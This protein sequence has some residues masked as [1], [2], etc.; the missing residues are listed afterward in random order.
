MKIYLPFPFPINLDGVQLKLTSTPAPIGL[1]QTPF[2]LAA[3]KMP[4]NQVEQCHRAVT[5]FVVKGLHPFATVESPW[6][7]EMTKALNPRYTPPSRTVLS[8]TLIPAWYEVEKQNV[9]TELANVS[10]VAIT[11]DGWTSLAQDHYI[12]VT[13]HY[14]SQ[15]KL[16]QK[17]LQTKAVYRAQTGETVAV[18]IGEVLEEFGITQKVVVMTVDNASNMDVAAKKLDILKLG[19]FAHT[20][21]LAAQKVYSIA[22]MTRWAAKLRAVIVWMKRSSMAKV[23]LKEKQLLLKLPQHTMI[24]DVKT[25]WNSLFLMV[26]RFLEQYPALQAAVLDPRIRKPMERDRLDRITDEDF[27]KA[28]EFIKVMKVLYTS[29]LCVSSEKT[30]TCGQILPILM[31]LKT[32]FTVQEGDSSFVSDIKRKVLTDLSGR[33]QEEKI[34]QFLEEA[35]AM[36][37]S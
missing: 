23:V 33:Y 11:S 29:T 35:T 12:T 19:C 26:E 3:R 21:N 16:Q 27:T 24:L 28:E 1:L 32:H 13:A 36:D 15:G 5:K 34:Q 25:R 8:N 14:S 7:R 9:I 37:P 30:P 22:T 17:V 10:K 6:F 31:K 2:T 20:L 4:S 18:E